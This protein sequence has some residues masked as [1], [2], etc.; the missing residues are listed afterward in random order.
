MTKDGSNDHAPAAAGYETQQAPG[1]GHAAVMIAD[2][3][4]HRLQACPL[5]PWRWLLWKP[6]RPR[7]PRQQPPRVQPLKGSRNVPS[8]THEFV[9]LLA[10]IVRG[11]CPLEL[12]AARAELL[13]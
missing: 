2:L 4:Q 5:L 9:D 10:G 13:G 1:D 7:L 11:L 3:G 12:A 6:D 8:P